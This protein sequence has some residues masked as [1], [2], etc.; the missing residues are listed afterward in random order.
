MWRVPARWRGLARATSVRSGKCP[1]IPHS[2]RARSA[3]I[4]RTKTPV[5][6]GRRGG[7]DQHFPKLTHKSQRRYNRLKP[8]ARVG[9]AKEDLST[10]LVAPKTRVREAPSPSLILT[11]GGTFGSLGASAPPLGWANE[12]S[13]AG[14]MKSVRPEFP[15]SLAQ[16]G[17]LRGS[18]VGL[19]HRQ[20]LFTRLGDRDSVLAERPA[21]PT[22]A[23]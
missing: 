22:R 16:T 11:F 4:S 2:R 7:L 12:G 15:C 3:R 21:E 18:P 6:A 19:Q 23:R 5:M 20:E 10:C 14:I 17:A 13:A 1:G 9:P 8:S